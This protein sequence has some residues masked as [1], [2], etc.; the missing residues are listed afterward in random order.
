MKNKE[1]ESREHI[2][3]HNPKH[4]ERMVGGSGSVLQGL[5]W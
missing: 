3:N 4:L 5:K 1:S 2:I